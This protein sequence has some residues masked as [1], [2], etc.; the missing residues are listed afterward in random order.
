MDAADEFQIAPLRAEVLIP[1]G[2]TVPEETQ[3]N[4]LTVVRRYRSFV[5][6]L[7]RDDRIRIAVMI[8]LRY[9]ESYVAFDVALKLKISANPTH[10][11]ETA[12]QEIVLEGPLSPTN[13]K[14]AGR[15]VSSLLDSNDEVRGATLRSIRQWPNEEGF[16]KIIEYVTPQLE[17][18]ELGFLKQV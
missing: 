15:L 3:L 6:D 12:M 16:K 2:D 17:S 18:G 1:F 7:S 10:A 5:P 13:I 9:A 4:F 8:V 11:V 14:G